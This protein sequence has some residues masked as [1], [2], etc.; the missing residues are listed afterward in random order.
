M[1][2]L[3]VRPPPARRFLPASA[4]VHPPASGERGDKPRRGRNGA[5]HLAHSHALFWPAFVARARF[6]FPGRAGVAVSAAERCTHLAPLR[7]CSRK[8]YR[9]NQP[10]RSNGVASTRIFLRDLLCQEAAQGRACPVRHPEYLPLE[11]QRDILRRSVCLSGGQV[12]CACTPAG[13]GKLRLRRRHAQPRSYDNWLLACYSDDIREQ[14]FL[15]TS[16]SLLTCGNA[17][18]CLPPP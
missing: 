17:S 4:D 1:A 9:P 3:L 6:P 5:L 7:Q 11:Y 10:H 15:D 8:S 13:P 14:C 2:T 18:D 12:P 16:R